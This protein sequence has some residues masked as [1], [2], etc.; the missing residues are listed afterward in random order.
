MVDDYFEDVRRFASGPG[1]G[2]PA[3]IEATIVQLNDLYQM[4]I[5]A[6]A[7]LDA[8]Q[9]LPPPDAANKVRAEGGRVPEPVRS[10]LQ[11][12]VDSGMQQIKA[13]TRD[14][15]V[16]DLKQTWQQID[17]DLRSQV[18]GF[19]IP[20]ING[21]YP[22]VGT[23]TQDVTPDDFAR[24]FAPGGTLEAFFQKSLAPQVDTSQ[25]PWRFKD[26]ALGQSRALAEFQ[27]AQVIRD[28]FFRSGG[29]VPTI[30]LEFKPVQMDASILRFDLDVDGKHVIYTHGPRV[31]TRVQFP[32]PAGRSEVRVSISPSA[33]SGSNGRVFQGP[34][35]LLRLFDSVQIEPTNQPDRFLAT[36][37]V[38]GRNAIF[39]VFAASVRNPFRLP[40]LTQF[41]CPTGL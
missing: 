29:N 36:I 8:A 23:S 30:Q 35:A 13:K 39:E 41:R 6:K 7:A 14:K 38:D 31:P 32:G 37:G 1:G 22:F 9:A 34:W 3:P 25:K 19:C 20:A 40:E 21:R 26:P 27:R 5:A 33:P 16:A 12:L 4:L 15:E 11:T 18:T 28:V 10:M 17:A 24:L 2:A